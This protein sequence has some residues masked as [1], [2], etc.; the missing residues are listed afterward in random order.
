[1]RQSVV[2]RQRRRLCTVHKDHDALLRDL[3]P[4]MKPT[5][6]VGNRIDSIL[7]LTGSIFP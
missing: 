5:V 4:D 3:N 1:V 7:E 6:G 2:D